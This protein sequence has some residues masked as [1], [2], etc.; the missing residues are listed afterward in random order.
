V[1]NILVKE[2]LDKLVV[3]RGLAGSRE[4][5]RA[6]IMAGKVLVGGSPVTKA[7]ALVDGDAQIEL[8]AED[9]PYVS[10]GGLKLEAA[11]REFRIELG[12]KTAMDVGAST[13]GFTDCMLRHGAAKVYAV[14]VGYGQIDLKLRQDPRVALLERTN[15]RY[16]ER[17]RV[18]D[19]IDIAVV[20]VSFISLKIVMPRI[21]EFVKPGGE[22]VALIKPQFE[23]GRGDV[24]KGGVVRDEKKRAEAV[25]A[26]EEDMSSLGLSVAGV[27]ESPLRGPKGN[28]EYLIHL[29]RH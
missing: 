17:E 15:I 12:G 7:G 13:G 2:R 10:R 20:D 24:G 27:M 28:V 22:I 18:P 11:L 23:V 8:K 19:E 29:R 5:A 21:V 3:G 25:R 16:L 14:D 4:R 6:L 1:K 26:V 9:I